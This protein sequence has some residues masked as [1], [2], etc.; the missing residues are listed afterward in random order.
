MCWFYPKRWKM[1]KYFKSNPLSRIGK[2]T[3]GKL[4]NPGSKTDQT[5]NKKGNF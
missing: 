1:Y 2:G 3:N 5:C 4:V